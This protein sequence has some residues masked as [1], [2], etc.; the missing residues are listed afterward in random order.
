M[1]L[2]ATV[3]GSDDCVELVQDRSQRQTVLKTV[4]DLLAPFNKEYVLEPVQCL[5]N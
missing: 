5:A 3:N 1:G 2:K 4:M